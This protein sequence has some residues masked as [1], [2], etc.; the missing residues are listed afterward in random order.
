MS[1]T[2]IAARQRAPRWI[3]S[4]RSA[5]RPLQRYPVIPGVLLLL[6]LSSAIAAPLLTDHD[7]S[8]RNL[9]DRGIP[10]VWL[11]GGGMDHPFGT[12][13]QGR[14]ILARILYGAR[15]SLMVASISV[16][17]GLL[18][19]TASGLIAGYFG[20]IVDEIIMRLVDMWSAL[21]FLLLAMVVAIS[22]GPSLF[23][24]IWLL[25]VSSWS[26][27]ARNIRG[28]VLGIKT[29]EYVAVARILDAS[30]IRIIVRHI[31]PQ[32]MHVVIVITT[33][34]SGNLIIAEAGL[35]FLGVGVP[36]STPTWGIM[37][38]EGRDFLLTSWWQAIIPGVFILVTVMSF[39]FVG[40]WLRDRWDPHLRQT[41]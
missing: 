22:V 38:A 32:V 29:R 7:P 36:A 33:L 30:D 35:S 14:D 20:G 31:L 5:I 39:N 8:K 12:D 19:G 27:G 2:P 34:R 40:D 26:A 4:I 25:G 15:I 17:V 16:T 21:P 24:V 37:I 1:K 9:R 41:A 13:E 3:E 28:E 23:T 6:L 18:F 11:E 10:P